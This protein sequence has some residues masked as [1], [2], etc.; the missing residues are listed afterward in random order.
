MS[1]SARPEQVVGPQPVTAERVQFGNGRNPP[2][3]VMPGVVV[4]VAE[5]SAKFVR[6]LP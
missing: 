6:G 2:L 1:R 5:G 3:S 4:L